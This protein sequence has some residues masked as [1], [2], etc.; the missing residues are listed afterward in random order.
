MLVSFRCNLQVYRARFRDE[1]VAVKVFGI[2][3]QDRSEVGPKDV[4]TSTAAVVPFHSSMAEGC[5]TLARVAFS[6]SLH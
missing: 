2:T 5:S 1:D 3:D 4:D 6:C